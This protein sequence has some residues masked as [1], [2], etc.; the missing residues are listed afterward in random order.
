MLTA[1]AAG[2]VALLMLGLQPIVLGEMLGAGR[3]TLEGVGLVAMA[4]IVTLGL[5]VLLG[6]R[7]G[8]LTHL[9]P[10]TVAAALGIVA[11][12]ALTPGVQGDGAI[13][14]VRAAAGLAEGLLL[15][16]TTAVIVRSG[17][18]ARIAGVFFVVQTAAQAVLGLALA[19]WIIPA[20]GWQAGFGALAAAGA[21]PL[22]L[23]GGLPRTL[24]PLAPAGQRWFRWSASSMQPLL[25]AFL[26]MA[27]LGAFWAYAEPLGLRA[28]LDAQGAQTV[29]AVAL[30]A[31]IVGGTAGTAVVRRVPAARALS[32]S[33][34]VLGAVGLAVFVTAAAH[35][36]FFPLCMVFAFTWLFM[37]PFHT[38]FAFAADG[39]G[40]VASLMP[41]AQ[42][43]GS[44][45]GPLVASLVVEGDDAS[46][47][48]LVCAA[49]AAAALVV[50]AR[51]WRAH[52][53]PA[54]QH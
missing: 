42:L 40:R 15:W 11:L 49:F 33:A 48:A 8:W 3:V 17:Q 37:T 2:S 29:I 1:M 44:A 16:V 34:L 43:L 26:L 30:M 6:D 12:D 20:Y 53:I 28:G 23:V 41:V 31:Q 38:A 19:R 21:L 24:R 9:R 45:A 52:R 35:A 47:A 10:L 14:G 36:W 54:L 27:S 18:P 46:R 51:Q 39:S 4:E 25:A 5:G 32:M 13:A 50:L 22:L 7:L